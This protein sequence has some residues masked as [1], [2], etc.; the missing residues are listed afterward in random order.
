[1]SDILII[2]GGLVGAA[3]ALAL[4]QQG[5]VVH[6]VETHPPEAPTVTLDSRIYA[7]SP[8]NA[9][10]LAELGVWPRVPAERLQAIAR[11]EVFGDRNG[12][13]EFDAY[14]ACVP[15]LSWMVENR[16][17][18]QA[19]WRA[20]RAAGVQMI[21]AAPVALATQADGVT[22][23]FADGRSL[24]AC[25]LLA[26]DGAHSWTRQACGIKVQTRAYGQTAVVANFATSRP[27]GGTAWQWF[28]TD[29]ILAYLPLPGQRMSMV[30]SL[31]QAEA[32]RFLTLEAEAFCRS[33]QEAGRYQLGRL[34]L[35]QR[36]AAFP[37]HLSLA[38]NG[39]APRVLLLGD[40]AHTVHPLAGQGV[41]LGLRDVR[42]LADQ[43]KGCRD[44]GEAALLQRVERARA[45][46]VWLM[47]ATC[48]GLQRLF[49]Q[50]PAWLGF[51]RNAGLSLVN[52]SGLLKQ[53]LMRQALR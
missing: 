49:N 29:R 31:P 6:L 4:R 22:C 18:Q 24:T 48:D 25:L 33:V 27:H 38:A 40:A 53:Q 32:E 50:A 19:L 44:P 36:P 23:E 11:M 28:G 13:L 2:G 20:C 35:L 34:E 47:Q 3:A 14:A 45:S 21:A 39:A 1:M 37:L 43:L 16:V 42:I 15:A 17:L 5:Y 7:V 52:Q 46:E 12:H 8:G 10:W 9:D 51:W 41:N 30:Y 26:A